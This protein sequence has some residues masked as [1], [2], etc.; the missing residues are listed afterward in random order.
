MGPEGYAAVT[1]EPLPWRGVRPARGALLRERELAFAAEAVPGG[2]IGL[3][4]LAQHTATSSQRTIAQSSRHWVDD[5]DLNAGRGHWPVAFPRT[6]AGLR[7]AL[8]H[9]CDI[10]QF[11]AT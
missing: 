3:A 6:P 11:E 8:H 10:S 9:R 2:I 1:A 7:P 4:S 5:T